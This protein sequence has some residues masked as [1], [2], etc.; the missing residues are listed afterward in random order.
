MRFQPA[1]VITSGRSYSYVGRCRPLRP[2]LSAF[3]LWSDFG[4]FPLFRRFRLFGGWERLRLVL[5]PPA[6]ADDGDGGVGQAGQVAGRFASVHS[7]A[8]LVPKPV[9]GQHQEGAV[10]R[11]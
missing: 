7:G 6:Q 5:E 1:V 4:G 11:D 8:V 2:G 10:V 3:D 9:A